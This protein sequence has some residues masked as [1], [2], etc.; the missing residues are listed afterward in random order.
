MKLSAAQQKIL[1]IA[2]KEIREAREATGLD[3]WYTRC[4][5]CYNR[6][7]TLNKLKEDCPDSFKLVVDV[8]NKR[9]NGIVLTQAS[10]P[11][12]RKLESLGLIKI[13][14][15]TTGTGSYRFDT[16]RVL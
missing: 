10:G 15:D 14:N 7:Y 11:T 16:I 12:I 4:Y 1:E 9:L 13:L 8:Y 3:D 5:K 6:N 2:R